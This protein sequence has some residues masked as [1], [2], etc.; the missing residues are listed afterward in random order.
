VTWIVSLVHIQGF[1]G[2]MSKADI[3]WKEHEDVSK[4]LQ[5]IGECCGMGKHQL[6]ASCTH[7]ISCR[8]KFF[9]LAGSCGYISS[10]AMMIIS[11]LSSINIVYLII[12]SLSNRR[13]SRAVPSSYYY[14][15]SST[16]NAKGYPASYAVGAPGAGQG[17][18]YNSS[19]NAPSYGYPYGATKGSH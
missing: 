8:E 19:G 11:V 7:P 6:S 17:A 4:M 2:K 9:G 1:G 12:I 10:I 16:Q 18:A 13:A 14:Y 5:A 15:G 3:I